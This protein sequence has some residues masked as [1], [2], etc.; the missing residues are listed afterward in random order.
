[1]LYGIEHLQL[2]G[3]TLNKINVRSRAEQLDNT[4]RKLRIE[5]SV[6]HLSVNQT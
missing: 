6:S 3:G 4:N 5:A 1:M 2:N